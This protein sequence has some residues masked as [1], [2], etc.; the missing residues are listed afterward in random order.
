MQL[1]KNQQIQIQRAVRIVGRILDGRKSRFSRLILLR[2][3]KI[4][5]LLSHL[6]HYFCKCLQGIYQRV[7]VC[8]YVLCMCVCVCVCVC[9]FV[10]VCV[11][12]YV[13]VCVCVCVCACVCV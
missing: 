5:V 10:F 7:Y 12:V 3:V 1:Q 11:Y 9:A 2:R 13:C 8:I 6:L 4:T